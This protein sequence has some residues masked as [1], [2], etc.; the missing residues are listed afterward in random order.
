MQ[1]NERRA[2]S[3]FTPQHHYN[4]QHNKRVAIKSCFLFK[5]SITLRGIIYRRKNKMLPKSAQKELLFTTQS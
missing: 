2:H 1:F 3:H 4:I 5:H